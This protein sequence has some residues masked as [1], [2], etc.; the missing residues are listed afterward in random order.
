MPIIP[1]KIQWTCCGIAHIFFVSNQAQ[2]YDLRV[3]VNIWAVLSF[4]K[5]ITKTLE[6][7][8]VV[9]NF[10]NGAISTDELS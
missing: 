7:N 1:A 8:S 2:K 10:T 3:L 9:F 4:L 6:E 5:L